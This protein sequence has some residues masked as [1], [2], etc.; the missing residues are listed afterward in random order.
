M[1]TA[2]EIL[3]QHPGTL[4]VIPIT[5]NVV[6]RMRTELPLR[7]RY[8]DRESVAQTH[9]ITTLPT[10]ALTGETYEPVVATGLAQI[11]ELLADQLDIP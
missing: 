6:R 3:D 8:P 9:L 1:V 7:A 2:T 4:H 11:R 5:S 10:D